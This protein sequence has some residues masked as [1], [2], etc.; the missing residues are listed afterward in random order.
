MSAELVRAAVDRRFPGTNDV[1]AGNE[2]V[3]FSKPE[4]GR[5]TG[6]DLERVWDLLET[7]LKAYDVRVHRSLISTGAELAASGV[8][9]RHYGVINSV[10]CHGRSA[11]T[12]DAEQALTEQ[13]ADELT[14]GAAVLGGHQFLQ[15]YSEFTPF[16]LGT[17]FA[18]ISVGRLGPG[19]Y[20][21]LAAVDGQPVVILNGFHPRQLAMFTAED[22]VCA[23]LHGSSATSWKSLRK[24]MTGTTDPVK[25]DPGSIRGA[26]FADPGGFGL[27]SVSTNYNG[28]HMSAG[29]L[30]GLGELTRFFGGALADWTFA[31]TLA[32]A[33]VSG[34]G[35][36]AL[37]DNPTL[38]ADG[39]RGSAFDLTEEMDAEPAAALLR[40]A[41][42][43]D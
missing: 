29:P 9:A 19:T 41:K 26:L 10:S 4:L 15:E 22:T 40:G 16:S 30:E 25:A 20:A 21:G 5:L 39:E 24:E 27:T 31:A 18:N 28:V 14:A 8:M 1:P 23:F 7:T 2:F 36:A 3:I 43:V 11:L 33:G 38:E 12:E 42:P 17:L 6:D 35:V 32:A 13:Y 37:V 34:D